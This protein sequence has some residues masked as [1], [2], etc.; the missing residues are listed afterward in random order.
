[1]KKSNVEVKNMCSGPYNDLV[2]FVYK[3]QNFPLMILES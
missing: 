2:A 1:M 3:Q